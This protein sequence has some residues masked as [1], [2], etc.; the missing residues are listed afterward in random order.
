MAVH[1]L[2]LG[3]VDV[4]LGALFYAL[5][6][7]EQDVLDLLEVPLGWRA[8][9]GIALGW[10]AAADEPGRSA[11][12]PRRNLDDLIHRGRWSRPRRDLRG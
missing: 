7:H 10:P 8:M 11:D 12:R 1:A 2:L 4:G 6:D 5:F 9:G 3:A